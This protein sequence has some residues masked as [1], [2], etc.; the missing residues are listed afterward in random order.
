MWWVMEIQKLV[1]IDKC[2]YNKLMCHSS[3]REPGTQIRMDSTEAGK[4]CVAAGKQIITKSEN[5]A[6]NR[7]LDHAG[8]KKT[9]NF[10]AVER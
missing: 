8:E 3:W 6:I 4:P 1:R 2:K 10:H 7:K 5:A 9:S